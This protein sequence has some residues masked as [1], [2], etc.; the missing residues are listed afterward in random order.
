MH[1]YALTLPLFDRRPPSNVSHKGD[2]DKE[3]QQAAGGKGGGGGATRGKR[4]LLPS[5]PPTLVS[6]EMRSTLGEAADDT[7]QAL[8]QHVAAS[9]QK[10][11]AAAVEGE[12]EGAAAAAPPKRSRRKTQ[13]L[14]L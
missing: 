2:A 7:T 14:R 8:R 11:A 5:E 1:L 4:R 9:R 12:G 13:F 10:L 6:R 3:N